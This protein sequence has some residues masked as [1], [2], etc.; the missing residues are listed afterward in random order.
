M[1]K[2][3]IVGA[4]KEVKGTVKDAFGKVAGNAKLQSDG[5][6]ERI[7]GKVQNAVGRMKDTVRQIIKK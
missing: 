2:D 4:A 6:A 1:D 3:R 7:A 5:K